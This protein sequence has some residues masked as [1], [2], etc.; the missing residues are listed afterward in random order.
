[1]TDGAKNA[2]NGA[3]ESVPL[4][5]FKGELALPFGRKRIKFGAAIVFGDAFF[6]GDPTALD[7]T[8]QRW[9]KRALLDL[10]HVGGIGFD[11]FSDGVAMRGARLEGAE[12][13]KVKRALQ[14]FDAAGGWLS[15]HSRGGRIAGGGEEVKEVKE[16]EAVEEVEEKRRSNFSD[17]SLTGKPLAH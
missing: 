13:Q 17:R 9:I 14:K 3:G 2:R 7:E 16:V 11:G 10:Q 12:D 1:M 15:R 5:G 4:A 8:V 6:D